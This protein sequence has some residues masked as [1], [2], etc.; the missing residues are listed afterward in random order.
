MSVSVL[1]LYSKYS[2]ASKLIS[3]YIQSITNSSNI[4]P[5]LRHILAD[6]KYIDI[7]NE[8]TRRMILDSKNIRVTYVPTLLIIDEGKVEQYEGEKAFEFIEQYQRPVE[9]QPLPHNITTGYTSIQS[10]GINGSSGDLDT[11]PIQIVESSPLGGQPH[12]PLGGQPHTPL[13]GQP[14]TPLG[15]Q[16]HTPLGGQPLGGGVSH[17]YTENNPGLNFQSEI[18]TMKPTKAESTNM[19]VSAVQMAKSR[20][21]SD[22]MMHQNIGIR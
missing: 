16:P 6:L 7:D 11:E 13:G 2:S 21:D 14:H 18:V 8:A 9:P 19:L 12:T 5:V 1:L 15:G 10:L 22:K 3:E 20:D 17:R 4:N